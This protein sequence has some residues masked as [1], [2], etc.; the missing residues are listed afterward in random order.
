MWEKMI[1]GWGPSINLPPKMRPFQF[2][3]QHFEPVTKYYGLAYFVPGVS[4]TAFT[5]SCGLF[6]TDG[7]LG[8]GL[9]GLGLWCLFFSIGFKLLSGWL[10]GGGLL[11]VLPLALLAFL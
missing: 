10:R 3:V 2:G 9:H 6:D 7:F 5:A 11:R 8:R 1:R 4:Q